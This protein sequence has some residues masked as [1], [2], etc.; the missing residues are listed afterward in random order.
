MRRADVKAPITEELLEYANKNP[1]LFPT[2]AVATANHKK[3][4]EHIELSERERI[5]G[6]FDIPE[7]SIH[8]CGCEECKEHQKSTH[9]YY[10]KWLNC[11]FDIIAEY[12]DR[13]DS[14][15]ADMRQMSKDQTR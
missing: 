5:M 4:L 14:I 7:L 10:L 2:L 9:D 3:T 1:D 8:D 11:V 6:R 15:S 12:A 13:I